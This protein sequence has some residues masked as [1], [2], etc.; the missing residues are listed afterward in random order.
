MKPN[1]AFYYP[2]QRWRDTDW[3]KNLICFFDG[4][5]MLIPGSAEDYQ[6][7][8]DFPI[9]FA[10]KNHEL[11]RVIRPEEIIDD[12]ATEA[13]AKALSDIIES[14]RLDHLTRFDSNRIK[15]SAFRSLARSKLGYDGNEKLADAILQELESRGLADNSGE[16]SFISM[17]G[18]VGA[19]ILTLLAQVLSRSAENCIG[20]KLSPATDQK[21]VVGAL[22]EIISSTD[23]P[24]PSV[25]D[26]VSFDMTKVGVDLGPVPIDEVLDFRQQNYRQ[27]RD[28][29]QSVRDFT[30]E[31][32]RTP[33]DERE[34]K[35]KQRQEEVEERSSTLRK[36]YQGSWKKPITFGISLT[37]A[38]WAYQSGDPIASA[39]SASAAVVGTLPDESNE[40]DVYSY[41]ISAKERF[42]TNS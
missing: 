16:G 19:L 28:Y 9:V 22:N 31:L 21:Q 23:S 20:L 25:G 6:P 11:F 10:L 30:R 26:V 4:I 36:T 17:D 18:T 5:A 1:F 7:Y 33:F 27:H 14:G 38:V 40:I 3:V 39:L 24:S 35:F 29:I 42:R 32:S 15:D 13:L 34:V 2:G 37:G 12:K 41:L 8:D